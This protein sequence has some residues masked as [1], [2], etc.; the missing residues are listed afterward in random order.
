LLSDSTP[1]QELATVTVTAKRRKSS[2]N[3]IGGI[4]SR[5]QQKFKN[6]LER[7]PILKIL[8]FPRAVDHPLAPP[9]VSSSVD[10]LS[11]RE[12]EM[13]AAELEVDLMA[14]PGIG[15]EDI[16]LILFGDVEGF[17]FWSGS[18]EAME[19]AAKF[20]EAT[21][22]KTLEMTRAGRLMTKYGKALPPKVRYALWKR[23]SAR[24][25]SAAKASGGT[26]HVFLDGVRGVRAGSIWMTKE[27]PI[28]KGLDPKILL[29]TVTY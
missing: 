26:V 1:P 23:L 25:A 9:D 27:Y 7:Q 20:A 16:A 3:S 19:A 29:H 2:D 4:I 10:E 6:Y 28:L 12:S 18:P 13:R 14:I 5:Y 8:L 11:D 17:T 22:G 24:F 21:G 15:E